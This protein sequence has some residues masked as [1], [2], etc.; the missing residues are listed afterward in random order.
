M[1]SKRFSSS[2]GNPQI[3]A[4]FYHPLVIAG[5]DT[6]SNT[7]PYAFIK[8][9]ATGNNPQYVDVYNPVFSGKITYWMSNMGN[10]CSVRDIII[11][12]GYS[13]PSIADSNI[14]L[15][16][17]DTYQHYIRATGSLSSTPV[18][19]KMAQWDLSQGV[20]ETVN[21]NGQI[22]FGYA[23]AADTWTNTIGLDAQGGRVL[24][25]DN[26]TAATPSVSFAAALPTT[27]TWGKGSF[28][29]NSAPSV[30]SGKVLLG[31]SRLTTG[32]GN[33]SGTD[34]TPIYGTTS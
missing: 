13:A 25:G 20:R 29:Y 28:V 4:K 6:A 17:T 22:E 16:V 26:A 23:T 5:W 21:G 18:Y 34:W 11:Q 14:I 12:A 19:R 7:W 15:N 3:N 24:F 31:W 32:S 33:V 30:A 10:R 27:G 8:A 9:A 2:S 1:F